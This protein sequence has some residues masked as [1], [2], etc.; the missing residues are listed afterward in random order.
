MALRHRADRAVADVL[1]VDAAEEVVE[2]SLPQ[3]AARGFH[4]FDAERPEHRAQHRDAA[5]EHR[6]AVLAHA[7][8]VELLHR[9]RRD[10]LRA[11]PV[12]TL[13][14]DDPRPR[15]SLGEDRSDRAD[16]PGR[17]ER[18]LPAERLQLAL[19]RSQLEGR[20]D[21]RALEGFVA[22]LAVGEEAPRPRHA[23]HVEAGRLA[24][25]EPFADD[26]L[27]AAAADVD[28]EPAARGVRRVMRHP[29]VD[30]PRLL[31]A[32]DDLD[33]VAERLRRLAQELLAIVELAERR[34]ADGTHG[35]PRHEPQALAE[36]PETI[37]GALRHGVVETTVL[38]QALGE[39]HPLAQAVEQME[40]SMRIL[41]HHHVEAVRPEVDRG[42]GLNR[43]IRHARLARV[44][45][46]DRARRI[47][48]VA[49][50][51]RESVFRRG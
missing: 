29:E 47:P 24:G 22:E 18:L 46:R 3:R 7:R 48:R 16:R 1:V 25:L 15:P 9:L 51:W 31:A 28:D 33:R 37:E 17:A 23:A 12:E 27:G 10:D 39:R 40:V 34:R 35:L 21:L 5:G 42:D 20:G 38:R 26:D 4:R 11:Q 30:E 8:Q 6:L 32:R 13:R 43:P 45:G 41:R 2:H 19:H 50:A 36:A 14:R 44:A 49:R